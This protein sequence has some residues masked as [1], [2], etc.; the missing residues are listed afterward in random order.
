MLN[1]GHLFR[2]HCINHLLHLFQNMPTLQTV[3]DGEYCSVD[4]YLDIGT[5]DTTG[6]TGNSL[7]ISKYYTYCQYGLKWNLTKSYH[8][9]NYIF[10]DESRIFLSEIHRHSPR[11]IH[12]MVITKICWLCAV[13]DNVNWGLWLGSSALGLVLKRAISAYVLTMVVFTNG[14]KYMF[15]KLRI[16]SIISLILSD[17]FLK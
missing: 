17:L 9:W 7:I 12:S 1:V 10:K 6:L 2:Y 11:V 15:I 5:K 8:T 13:Y 3:G 14:L 4:S 16:T